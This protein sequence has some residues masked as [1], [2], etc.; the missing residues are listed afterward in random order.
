MCF[1]QLGESIDIHCGGVDNIFPHHENEIAQSES[2]SKKPFAKIWCHA[3]HLIVDGKKMSK[4]KKNFHTLRSL[5]E[6][7]FSSEEVRYLLLQGHYR[8]QLNFT[9]DGLIAAR[10]S[11][12]R[13]RDC[14]YRLEHVA[15]E[16]EGVGS[17]DLPRYEKAFREA[18]LD[19]L[20]ISSALGSLFDLI[21][22]ANSLMD[23]SKLSQKQ[24]ESIL[25][26]MRGMDQ[27]LGLLF[28]KEEAIPMDIQ[29]ALEQRQIARKEKN[30]EKADQLRDQIIAAGYVIDDTP[31]GVHLKKRSVSSSQ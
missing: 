20:H 1:S 18:I 23:H 29:E 28:P 26:M 12:Q 17:L 4:S 6:E 16:I 31:T 19:D 2:L 13:I 9:F 11:L 5:M 10:S 21:R 24:A 22:E 15:S 8:T 25:S 30:W 27:V 3:A 14:I 7:G